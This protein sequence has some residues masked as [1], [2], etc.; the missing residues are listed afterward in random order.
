MIKIG[1]VTDTNLLKKSK[2]DLYSCK[3]I[4]DSTDI[5][6]EYIEALN[7]TETKKELLYFM[8][9]LI[10]EELFSQKRFAFDEQYNILKNKYLDMNYVLEGELPKH[11]L[12]EIIKREKEDYL[13]KYKIIKLNYTEEL[14]ENIVS[15]AIQKKVPFDKS[16]EGKK[17]DAGFKDVLIWETILLADEINNCK[18]FYLFSADRVFIDNK[19]ILTKEFNEKHPDTELK[20]VY[21][22]PDG[23]QR[24]NA[25]HKIIEDNDLVETNVVK[26][27]NKGLI[28]ATINSIHYDYQKDVIYYNEESNIKLI[29][30]L[31]SEF[32]SDDFVIE[33]VNEVDEKYEV[34]LSF[35]T[36]K[37]TLDNLQKENNKPLLGKIKIYYVDN[38][39][40]FICQSY[41]LENIRFYRN[42]INQILSGI[43]KSFAK[44]YSEAV[45]SGVEKLKKALEIN[46]E[47]L[48]GVDYSMPMEELKQTISSINNFNQMTKNIN[49]FNQLA[50]LNKSFT[51][52]NELNKT[53]QAFDSIKQLNIY[54]EENKD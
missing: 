49:A 39:Q 40:Q 52:I 25:L 17:T 5:F 20:I 31:F 43:G 37:Y 11:N 36:K 30:V 9:E 7:K 33:D 50:E 27:Y 51:T 54:N 22:D 29:D 16:K 8:P 24:Q 21:F 47:P 4:L 28:L 18:I 42:Y 53:S 35:E 3:T 32:T 48:K 26:L 19:E 34:I 23:N 46:V 41:T 15:E 1:F 2:D 44:L 38:N 10:V 14:F 45:I 6:I 12:E 13:S